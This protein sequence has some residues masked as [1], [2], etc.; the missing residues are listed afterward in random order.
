M[1][2]IKI[3]L[4]AIGLE[5]ILMSMCLYLE[6]I[7]ATLGKA[8]LPALTQ[9]PGSFISVHLLP[10]TIPPY[11]LYFLTFIIQTILFSLALHLSKAVLKK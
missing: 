6:H 9:L 2:S 11:G 10:E 4:I 3:W 7:N 8:L 5:L 1:R